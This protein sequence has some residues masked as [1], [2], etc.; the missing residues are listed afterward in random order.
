MSR[1]V[2]VIAVGKKIDSAVSHFRIV[3]KAIELGEAGNE[4]FGYDAGQG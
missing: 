1:G 2:W 4:L 3:Q